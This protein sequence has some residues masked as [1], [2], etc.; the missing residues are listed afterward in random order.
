MELARFDMQKMDNPEIA[1]VEYLQG[2]LAGYEVRAYLLEKWHRCG[3]YCDAWSVPLQIDHVQPKARG[4]SNR[5]N[6]FTLACARCNDAK[7][8]LPIEVFPADKP[9]KLQRILVQAKRPLHDA[10]AVNA[11]R[12][13]LFNALKGIDLPI[14]TDTG[15]RTRWNRA[16]LAVPKAHATDA[17]WVGEVQALTAWP[18]PILSIK[19]TGRS[20]YQRTRL[21]RFG[22]PRGTLMRAKRVAG[23]QTGDMVRALR[24]A[25][26]K[27]A[28]Y[29]G[30]VAIRASKSFNVQT[31]DGVVQGIH[32]KHCELLARGD[33]HGYALAREH[34]SS[35]GSNPGYPGA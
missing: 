14:E 30:R 31:A 2:T 19:A 8:A 4:G 10:A 28:T 7:G 11:T 22:F 25:G 13:M 3:A 29:V 32:A 16:R 5:I 6:N 17:A 24:R 34:L 9:E 27:A 1:G 21:D 33:G 12:W 35:Q 26:K 20:T 18:R 15:G 23:F